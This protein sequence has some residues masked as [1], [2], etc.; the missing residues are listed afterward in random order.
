MSLSY[1]LLTAAKNE[2]KYIDLQLRSVLAQTVPPTGTRSLSTTGSNDATAK[3]VERYAAQH[4]LIRLIRAGASGAS[5]ALVR[6]TARSMLALP[7]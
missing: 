5:A 2:E 4:S 6:R 1:A 3:I 7:C